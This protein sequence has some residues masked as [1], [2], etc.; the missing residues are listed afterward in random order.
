MNI[1]RWRK[2][3]KPKDPSEQPWRKHYEI[4]QKV[5]SG[6]WYVIDK[7]D[8]NF[9]K[10]LKFYGYKGHAH[11]AAASYYRTEE[12]QIEKILLGDGK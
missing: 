6:M 2:Q 4:R 1:N 12:R 3:F 8:P 7:R 10:N 5:D 9:V 11:S